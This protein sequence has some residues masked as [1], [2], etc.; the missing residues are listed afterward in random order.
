MRG[1]P[2]A[3][4][5]LAAAVAL[6]AACD[7]DRGAQQQGDPESLRALWQ[8]IVAA[9]AAGRTGAAAT[10]IRATLPDRKALSVALRESVDAGVVARLEDMYRQLGA[11]SDADMVAGIKPER[12]NVVVIAATTEE[13][14]AFQSQLV[15]AAFPQG[16]RKVAMGTLRRGVTFYQVKLLEPGS[17]RGTTF[18]L[19]YWGGDRWRGLGPA[20]RAL[21]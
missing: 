19:Y 6:G 11:M 17:D 21:Q 16:A 13:L 1:L 3:A 18:H 14:A 5:A 12:T 8:S 4:A 9:A 10:K 2:I 20:W 7:R 15:K